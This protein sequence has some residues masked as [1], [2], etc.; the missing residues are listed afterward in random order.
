MIVESGSFY[1]FLMEKLMIFTHKRKE[2]K[3]KILAAIFFDKNRIKE[4]RYLRVFREEFPEIADYI[5]QLKRRDRKML[6]R[7]LQ[8][9]ESKFIIE[10]AVSS[11][12]Q[13]FSSKMEFIST[14][15]DSIVVKI[16]RL[17]D[18][19]QVIL[20]CFQAEG[21]NPRLSLEKF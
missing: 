3:Q 15:H 6:A 8:K 10:K 20:D 12:I 16:S 5:C 2:V 13:K 19:Y 1:E 4:S 11:F 9:A 14:I 17:Q 7:I 21:I 18:A